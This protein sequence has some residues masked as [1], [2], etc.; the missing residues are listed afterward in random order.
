M[1]DLNRCAA[2]LLGAL[3]ALA[4][5]SPARAD[6][7]PPIPDCDAPDGASTV[8]RQYQTMTMQP[9]ERGVLKVGPVKDLGVFPAAKEDNP[10]ATKEMFIKATRFCE[11]VVTLP[12]GTADPTYWRIQLTF[13]VRN[14]LTPSTYCSLKHD[15]WGNQCAAYR[16]PGAAP[17]R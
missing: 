14:W 7:S 1:R 5:A 16:P 15:V 3:S 11:A 4:A 12:D 10:Y 17:A 6:E 8:E 13:N 9:F 2:L